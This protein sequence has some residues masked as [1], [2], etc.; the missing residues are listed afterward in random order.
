MEIWRRQLASHPTCGREGGNGSRYG[1][2]QVENAWAGGGKRVVGWRGAPALLLTFGLKRKYVECEEV[3]DIFPRQPQELL[4][5]KSAK[6]SSFPTTQS[7]HRLTSRKEA[8]KIASKQRTADTYAYRRMAVSRWS[9]FSRLEWLRA[10][11][12]IVTHKKK[13]KK[14]STGTEKRVV[15]AGAVCSAALLETCSSNVADAT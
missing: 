4:L 15:S 12:R 14:K 6:I 11:H 10:G 7:C 5:I 8:A 13:R 3:K 2:W 9:A 1:R